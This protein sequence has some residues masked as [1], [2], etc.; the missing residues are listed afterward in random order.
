MGMG[1]RGGEGV[2]LSADSHQNESVMQQLLINISA[3]AGTNDV[4][5]FGVGGGATSTQ[6]SRGR[7]ELCVCICACRRALYYSQD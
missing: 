1:T 5:G 3:A 2:V 4:L 6:R 7:C